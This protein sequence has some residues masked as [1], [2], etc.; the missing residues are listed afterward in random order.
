MTD[1]ATFADPSG[2]QK[3]NGQL[4]EVEETKVTL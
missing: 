4:R 2:A 1:E 3:Y